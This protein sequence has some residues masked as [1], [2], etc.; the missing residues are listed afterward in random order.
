MIEITGYN[1][2]IE[3]LVNIAR[4]KAKIQLSKESIQKIN[5][6]NHTFFI[7]YSSYSN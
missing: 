7:M 2:D 5:E 4:N 1:L 3:T 6:C